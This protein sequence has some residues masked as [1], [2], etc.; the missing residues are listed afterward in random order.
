MDVLDIRILR[1][2][3]E[4]QSLGPFPSNISSL[5]RIARTL[6]IDKE[7]VRTRLARL[8]ERG[9][10]SG[11]HAMVNPRALSLK[12][13]RVWVEFPSEALKEE[14]VR[15]LAINPTLRVVYNY[16]GNFASFVATSGTKESFQSGNERLGGSPSSRELFTATMKFPRS[17]GPLGEADWKIYQSIRT[18]PQKPYK[19][20]SKETGL[21]TRTIKRR[22]S[23]L[24]ERNEILVA[25][26]LDPSRVDGV[27]ADLLVRYEVPVPNGLQE[28]IMEEIGESVIHVEYFEEPCVLFTIIVNNIPEAKE[29]HRRVSAVSGMSDSRLFFVQGLVRIRQPLRLPVGTRVPT[30]SP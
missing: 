28:R 2:I 4:Y 12:V 20:I 19:M 1:E 3:G 15:E 30:L 16:A 11:W 14:G 18:D 23:R 29:L 6:D 26:D 5:R 22:M 8:Q 9:I 27:S 21:G 25:P 13:S 10:L 24:I 17:D 7:T